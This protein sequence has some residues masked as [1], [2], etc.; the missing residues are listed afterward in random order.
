MAAPSTIDRT[1]LIDSE[2]VRTVQINVTPKRYTRAQDGPDCTFHFADRHYPYNDPRV[3]D[4][5]L[6]VLDILD[7]TCIGVVDHG[8]HMD[9]EQISSYRK[10]PFNRTSLGDE[11]KGAARFLGEIHALTPGAWHV[12][13]EGNHEERLKRVVWDAAEKR[14][15]GEILT[16]PGVA[17]RLEWGTLLGI[18]ELDWE[19]IPYPKHKLLWD[20]LL[21]LH[22]SKVRKDSGLSARAEYDSYHKSG[23]SG[24]THRR[25]AFH[26]RDYNGYHTWYEIG[27][28]GMVE[29]RYL[30]GH[31][32]WQQGVMVIA[33]NADRTEW[34]PEPIP[35]HDGVAY[36][37]GM[38]LEGK[39]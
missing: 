21:L 26:I 39:C 1:E 4:I 9:C 6:Q 8:D 35:I 3:D 29:E 24:H 38:R 16:L 10:D 17:E 31:A 36:F 33:W 34:G 13:L 15:L 23:L 12:W 19:V 11:I 28:S 14:A 25:G 5:I 22:G 2:I 27:M 18:E 20:K 37:R 32:N 30:N 7:D